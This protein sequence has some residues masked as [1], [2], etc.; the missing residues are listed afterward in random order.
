MKIVVFGAGFLG[1]RFVREVRG[2]VMSMADI[3]EGEQVRRFLQEEKPD[4]VI[5]CAGKTGRPNVD[6]CESNRK[7]TYR[8]NVSGALV[9]AEECAAANV[10]LIH[11]GSG[12]VF[13]GPSPQ[14]GGWLEDDHANPVSFYSR[15]KYAADLI[16]SR[17]P[18][19]CV[20]R[21]RMPI[22]DKPHPRNLVTKLVS[23][24]QVVDVENSVTVVQDLVHVVLQLIDKRAEGVFH[25]TNPGVLRHR[26]LL[27]LY[28]EHVDPRH[29]CEF[30]A[31]HELQAGPRSNAI[32][33]S[34]RLEALG[35]TM[36]PVWEAVPDAM[37]R[38]EY[39]A[40]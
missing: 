16:L 25:A 9:L 38:Y 10:F 7:Q 12:C 37:K 21:I 11:M 26:E 36:R 2:S 1:W 31:A 15:T 27:R 30:I 23:Y 3:A 29:T 20:V 39:R 24:K 5:N 32:L 19:V 13:Y 34:P 40:K 4:V 6:W 22:D 18:D 17:L 14:Q 33:A 28:K 35:I 8:S